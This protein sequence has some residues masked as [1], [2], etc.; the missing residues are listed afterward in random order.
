MRILDLT[1][2]DIKQVVRDW[3]SALFLIVMPI[4]FTLFFGFVLNPVYSSEPGQEGRLPIGVINQDPGGAVSSEFIRL[5]NKSD[6]VRP[7]LFEEGNLAQANRRVAANEL[8]AAV[9]IP[10]GYS[11]RLLNGQTIDLEVVADQNTLAGQTASTALETAANRL[12]GAVETAQ[13]SADTLAQEVGF[14]TGAERDAYL[15]QGLAQAISAWDDPPLT[16]RVERA[17]GL[18]AGKDTPGTTSGFAQASAGMIVQFAVFGLITSAMILV[19][20]RKNKVLQRLLTTP[21]RRTEVIAGHTLAM[22]LVVFV[23]EVILVL[24]GQYAFGVNYLRQPGATLLMMLGL[25][26]WAASLGLLIGAI[27]QKEDQVIV[28]SLIAMFV[29]AAMGGAWFPLEVTG[30]TFAAIGHI[31]P[32]AWAMDGFQNIIMRGLSFS[33]VLVPAGILAVYSALFFA[34]AV[35]R[36]R[37]E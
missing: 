10:G 29:F 8:A 18:P 25:A 27:S 35:W 30:K 24:L 9:R 4:L 32:T 15:E 21:I 19:L 33:S 13:L 20:E 6:V 37:F 34:L 7:I 11:E 2:K 17:T 3:K 28:L 22:F 16:V 23:Q 14:E 12:L 31:M 1:I 26:L 36:F 5:L